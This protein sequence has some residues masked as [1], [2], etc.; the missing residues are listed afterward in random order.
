MGQIWQPFISKWAERYF[1]L[2]HR[3][4]IQSWAKLILKWGNYF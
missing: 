1:K 4:L 2:G 3:Q